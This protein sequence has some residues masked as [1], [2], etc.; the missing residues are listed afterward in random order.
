MTPR[1]IKQAFEQNWI[2]E[3]IYAKYEK[4]IRIDMK[5]RFPSHYEKNFKSY[6]IDR[7]YFKRTYPSIYESFWG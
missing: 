6:W 7:E 1:N 3:K 5:R 4:K 2:V